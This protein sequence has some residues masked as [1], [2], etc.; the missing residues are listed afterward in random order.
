MSPTDPK[1]PTDLPAFWHPLSR[2]EAQR[3]A[4]AFAREL[5]AHHPLASTQW[6]LIARHAR[7]DSLVAHA[8]GLEPPFYLLHLAWDQGRPKDPHPLA[9]LAELDGILDPPSDTID[10]LSLWCD[11]ESHQGLVLIEHRLDGTQ[12]L[13]PLDWPGVRPLP[14]DD[15]ELKQFGWQPITGPLYPRARHDGKWQATGQRVEYWTRPVLNDFM[16]FR[17]I[18]TPGEAISLRKLIPD[19]GLL[20]EF[21]DQAALQTGLPPGFYC[22]FV[23]PMAPRFGLAGFPPDPEQ[24]TNADEE[25]THG[26]K[27]QTPS[28]DGRSSLGPLR[29]LL[30]RFW[31][32]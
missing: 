25:P 24:A 17:A 9:S 11:A 32:D 20:I 23:S 29:R 21:E 19:D 16:L 2:D 6:R 28:P 3:L 18:E 13:T 1:S 10:L 7:E 30:G 15:Q 12:R 31:Q 22:R 5:D 14:A 4:P 8:P 26:Q 27:Q